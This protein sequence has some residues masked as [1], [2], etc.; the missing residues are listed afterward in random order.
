MGVR[1]LILVLMLLVLFKLLFKGVVFVFFGYV[2]LWMSVKVGGLRVMCINFFGV[3][4]GGIVR[5]V[6]LEVMVFK[7]GVIF[8]EGLFVKV[9]MEVLDVVGYWGVEVSFF[10]R[11][12]NLCIGDV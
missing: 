10:G 12:C 9:L 1:I 8:M 11:F 2:K 5:F 4:W 3:C 7:I 6:V